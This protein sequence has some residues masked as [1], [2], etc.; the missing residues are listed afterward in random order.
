MQMNGLAELVTIAR[1]W[2]EWADP[3]LVVVVLHNN[4]LNQVTWELRAMGGTPRF[5]ESQALPDIS[6]ADFATAVG[7][8]ATTVRDPDQLAGAW[9]RALSADRPTVL[10]I[11]CDPDVPPIPPHATLEQMTD[12]AKALI[13][14][15]T[16]R[17]GV[18]KEGLKTK[19]QELIPHRDD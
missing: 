1:Y 4:D 15:D 14:G 12:M 18:I 16:S 17:W 10:D 2:E 13:K 9:Q 19:A 11:L 6:Y 3:R 7:L 5:I 8:E